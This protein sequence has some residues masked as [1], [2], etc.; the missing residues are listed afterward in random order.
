MMNFEAADLLIEH[1]DIISLREAITEGLD[2]N[3]ANKYGWTMLMSAA[4]TGN[5]PIG[6]LLLE[7]GAKTAQRNRFNDTALS[8]AIQSGHPSFVR[9]LLEH[10][11]SKDCY[12]HGNSLNVFLDW[13]QRYC[14]CSGASMK[15][16]RSL[17]GLDYTS[18]EA[19]AGDDAAR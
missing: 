11:A 1:N 8:L 9:L 5:V 18:T 7:H 4:M 19:S 10:G 3:L 6:R 16:I 14:S 2:S 12:P 15:K 17:L 13:A